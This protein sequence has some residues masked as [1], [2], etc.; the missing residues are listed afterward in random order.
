MKFCA[1]PTIVLNPPDSRAFVRQ[2]H[3]IGAARWCGGE[4]TSGVPSCNENLE[5]AALEGAHASVI[6]GA[7]AAVVV[8][9][10][11][12][13]QAARQDARIV[14]LDEQIAAADGA[15]R[16]R[17]RS[18][19]A[20]LWETVL[21]EQRGTLAAEFDA[22]HS[23][24]R[25]MQM[26]SVSRIVAPASLRPFLIDAV[27]RGMRRTLDRLAGDDGARPAHRPRV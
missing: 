12:V 24:E 19:R 18:E 11:D 22:V 27:E 20:A 10:R 26:G 14:A 13:E 7:P 23:I 5:A 9:A 15:E 16:Q 3:A 4:T 17:L 21:T 2:P 8:F 6:G 1:M 25:A